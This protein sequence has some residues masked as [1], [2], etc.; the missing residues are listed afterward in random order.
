MIRPN[1]VSDRRRHPWTPMTGLGVNMIRPYIP[2]HI[3]VPL[4][5]APPIHITP[6][7]PPKPAPKPVYVAPPAPPKPAPTKIVVAPTPTPQPAPRVT[8]PGSTT[9]PINSIVPHYFPVKPGSTTPATPIANPLPTP[10]TPG[11]PATPQLT[12]GM[13]TQIYCPAGYQS[14]APNGVPPGQPAPTC[15]PI[16]TTPGT[17]PSGEYPVDGVCTPT[18]VPCPGGSVDAAG[19][20]V[21]TGAPVPVG[22]VCPSGWEIDSANNCILTSNVNNPYSLYL[23]SSETGG[24]TGQTPALTPTT[25]ATGQFMDSAGNCWPDTLAGWMEASTLIAGVPN[26]EVVGGG[27]VAAVALFLLIRSMGGKRR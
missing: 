3:S 2:V 22:G 20:C 10:G 11:A 26:M 23:P 14:S 18:A 16:T 7:A 24:D 1:V 6:P 5:V 25:C 4:R 8:V 27:A 17:C 12:P 9:P 15:V 19:N 21:P 13:V